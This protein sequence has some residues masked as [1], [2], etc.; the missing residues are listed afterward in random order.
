MSGFTKKKMLNSH[1][2][3]NNIPKKGRG[4]LLKKFPCGQYDE[5]KNFYV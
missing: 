3:N 2:L 5:Q 4:L 1:G